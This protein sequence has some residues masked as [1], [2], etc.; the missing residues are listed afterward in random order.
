VKAAAAELDPLEEASAYIALGRDAQAEALLTDAI[1]REPDREEL[2]VKLLEIYAQ[3]RDK[4]AF[5]RRAAEFHTRTAGAGDNWSKVAAMGIVL[6]PAN[7]LFG[8]GKEAPVAAAS[9][10]R[11]DLD[12]N[13]DAQASGD[14]PD[15]AAQASPKSDFEIE[16]PPAA[17]EPAPAVA[18]STGSI[19]FEVEVPKLDV[20]PVTTRSAAPAAS[21]SDPGAPL[22]FKLDLG[23]LDLSLD[24]KKPAAPAGEHDPHWHDVQAKFD[25][26]K[27]YQEMG[28][29]GRAAEVL[30]E[31]MQ[32]GDT[33]QQAQARKLLDSLG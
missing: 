16:I 9:A 22:D 31:A 2:H 32:E 26:A 24:D 8:S 21:A 20:P 28:E 13:L 4:A 12:F 18:A 19:D 10:P 23:A 27:A 33:E 14:A 1:A 17:P 7:P 3:R 6:D 30:R 25:L 11:S 29:K 5:A 15:G